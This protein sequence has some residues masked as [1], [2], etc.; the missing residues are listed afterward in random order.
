MH[1]EPFT[2]RKA[3]EL[4]TGKP[5]RYRV[6][7]VGAGPVGLC[8][9]IDLAQHGIDTV[10]LDEDDK[11]SEGSRA[12]CFAK[13]TLEILDRLGVGQRAVDKGVVWNVGKLFFR[14]R[15]LYQFDLLPESGHKRPAFI[16]LQQ[17]YLEEFLVERLLRTGRVDLRWR[18]RVIAVAPRGG[19]RRR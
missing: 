12:I 19:G 4:A 3:P 7:I 8:M 18:S 14:D 10:L 15:Q 9:A 13:R 1:A 5:G 2:Y 17:Y 11:A 16:N 6:A